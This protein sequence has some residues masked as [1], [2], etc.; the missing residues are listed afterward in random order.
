MP[1]YLRGGS[2]RDAEGGCTY[3]SLTFTLDFASAGDTWLVTNSYPFTYSDHKYHLSR[4]LSSPFVRRHAAHSVL[5]TTLGNND[6][7]LLTVTED[8]KD[9]MP[10]GTGE[11]GNGGEDGALEARKTKRNERSTASSSTTSSSVSSAPVTARSVSSSR[12]MCTGETQASWMMKGILDFLTGDSPQ[13]RLLRSLFVFKIVPMLNPD[14]VFYGNNR[15]SLAGVDLNRQWKKPSRT[16]HPTIYYTKSM[17]RSEK[18]MRDVVLYCDLHGHSRKMNVFMYGCDD[19]KKP[20]PMTRIFPKLLS[21][22]TLGKKYLSFQDCSFAVKKARE[23]TARV[24]VAKEQGIPNSYTV[25]GTFA[26]TNFGGLKDM[27][28]NGNHFQEMGYAICDT[29]LDY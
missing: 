8:G 1:P 7:D 10:L 16:L 23:T 4:L 28:M 5:C 15:C 25:E 17:I 27:H 18:S 13:A 20:R 24:V 3:F 21:W 9:E 19:K 14:G 11:D 12:V 2:A 29:L 22:N 26:G 6:C